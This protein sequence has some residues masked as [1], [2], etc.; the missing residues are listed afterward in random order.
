[1]PKLNSKRHIYRTR[2]VGQS[3]MTTYSY[4]DQMPEVSL[5]GPV[6]VPTV[7]SHMIAWTIETGAIYSTP[8]K[9]PNS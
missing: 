3:F 9:S 4:T 5:P 6:F 2:Q 8:S 7:G 1:M